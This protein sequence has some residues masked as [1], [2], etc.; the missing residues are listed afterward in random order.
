MC[1]QRLGRIAAGVV[2]V[3][4]LVRA[5]ATSAQAPP[6]TFYLNPIVVTA[7]GLAQPRAA[8]PAAV[9][10]LQGDALRQQGIR[11]VADALRLVPGTN[12]VR[13]GS[14]GGL[15]SLFLRGGESDYVQV[16]VDGIVL[17]EP[18]GAFDWGQLTTDNVD[19]IEVVRGPV[20]VLYG[21]DAVTGVV[22][23]ITRAGTSR[24]RLSASASIGTESRRNAGVDVCPG[25]PASPCPAG[26]DLGRAGSTAFDISIT[27]GTERV[28]YAFAAGRFD[29]DG[30]YAFNND[31]ANRTVSGRA[32][33]TAS[34][35][36]AVHLTARWSDGVFH[37]PTDG[38]GRLVDRNQFRSTESVALG[39]DAG[40]AISS[41]VDARVSF[42]SHDGS[43]IT[44][45]RR[46][47]PADTLGSWESLN[48]I[49]IVRRKAAAH[50][51]LRIANATTL[52]AG[53][54]IESQDGTSV[55]T[56][57]GQFGPFESRADNQ[58]T[59]RAAFVQLIAL[60]LAPLSLTGGTRVEDNN[61]FGTF[62][63][64]RLGGNLALTPHTFLRASAGSAFKEPTFFENYAEGF[65]LG[66][67]ELEPEASR[68]WEIG[69]EQRFFDGHATVIATWFDQRFTNLIQYVA[70][71][72]VAGSPNY[73][74][75]GEAKSA[76]L[77]LETRA[78]AS[79]G[80]MLSA[81]VTWL[82]TEV[83][84]AGTG[85]DRLFQHGETLIRRPAHRLAV[86][87]SA[88]L[89]SRAT[90]FAS[91]ARVGQR[92]DLD[93]LND[94][95]G[96]RI[97]LPAY[98]VVN[99]GTELQPIRAF[100]FDLGVRVDNL[101]NQRYREVAGFPSAGRSL[102]VSARTAVGF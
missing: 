17:N 35:R 36:A 45:D 54:E 64:W 51:N 39:I 74:N 81:S 30:T 101:F 37:Y 65:T 67:P 61:R 95:R 60:P 75:L 8:V 20:S 19:R 94:F 57:D 49:A 32:G 102:H 18:G 82:D 53:A 90:L 42:S 13:V 96:E 40:F 12:V 16:M 91:L 15:T 6:D 76:G 86:S 87:A 63:T 47:G 9:T 25:Y 71:P 80:A 44:D 73:V 98:T 99:L 68:N 2:M 52:T 70:S 59:N 33:I 79:S 88:P 29:S 38:A 89:D 24:P 62:V 7:T 21:S 4:T 92:D 83:L 11:F 34:D 93:F 58:R 66:N 46:D 100:D 84:D 78:F 77:E 97:K 31:Y 22:H 55:F 3:S 27:G 48:D 85:E 1:E 5:E 72:P 43:F 28:E 26:A 56:S 50:A 14:H 41:R 10:V 69:F 23:I